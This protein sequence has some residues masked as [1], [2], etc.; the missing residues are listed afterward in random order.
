MTHK[1]MLQLMLRHAAIPMTDHEDGSISTERMAFSDRI[2]FWFNAHG[3]LEVMMH[4]DRV[5]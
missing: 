4:A 1:E 3:D 5:E 2:Q